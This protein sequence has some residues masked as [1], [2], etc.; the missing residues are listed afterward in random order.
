MS[1]SRL[2]FYDST[3]AWDEQEKEHREEN[4]HAA[5]GTLSNRRLP[6]KH[7]GIVRAD[8]DPIPSEAGVAFD[9]RITGQP[10]YA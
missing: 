8:Q 5:G 9:Y 1:Y 4:S 3:K 10:L 2:V 7:C 6:A